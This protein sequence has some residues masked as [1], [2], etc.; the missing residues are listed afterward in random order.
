MDIY[1][2]RAI[3]DEVVFPSLVPCERDS[4]DVI[5]IWKC[6]GASEDEEG[7]ISKLEAISV[8]RPS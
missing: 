2:T 7:Y 6:C 5:E 8:A 4:D 3:E 1:I